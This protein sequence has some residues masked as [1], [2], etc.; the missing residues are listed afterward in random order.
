MSINSATSTIRSSVYQT[1]LDKPLS[2]EALYK[3]KLKYGIYQSP[4]RASIGVPS[5]SNASDTAALLAASTDL[6]VKPY[7]RTIAEDAQTAALFAK[8]KTINAYKR[9]VAED[10]TSASSKALSHSKRSPTITTETSSKI[11][12][13]SSAAASSVLTRTAAK[14]I[15]SLASGSLASLYEF[16]AVR[17][18]TIKQTASINLSKITDSS[19]LKAQKA[20]DERWNPGKDYRSGLQ[21]EPK[22]T[23]AQLADFAGSAAL[24]IKDYEI[25]EEE[26]LKARAIFKNS[27][28]DA[29]VLAQASLNADKTLKSI[30]Q[31]LSSRDLFLNPEFNKAALAI[32]QLHYEKRSVAYNGKV[33]LG[34]GLFMTQEELDNIARKFVDPVLESIDKTATLQREK[35]ARELA[36]KQERERIH[37][38]AKE[39][40]K[41]AKLEEKRAKEEAK[42]Q[43]RRELEEEKSRQQKAKQE[44]ENLKKDELKKH[45]SILSSK[46][47]EEVR[48][49]EELLAKQKAEE[50]RISKEAKE[51]QEQRDAELQKAQDERD[52]KLEPILDE[53]KKES[54]KLNVLNEE[55]NALEEIHTTHL[56]KLNNAK[57]LLQTSRDEL[58]HLSSVFDQL[59]IDIENSTSDQ[60]KLSK[61][62]ES[63]KVEAEISEKK[64]KEIE[65]DA[66]VKN[67]EIEQLKNETLARK[68]ELELKLQA[69]KIAVLNEEKQILE[70]L[71][72]SEAEEI[73]ESKKKA[74]GAV[75]S[76]QKYSSLFDD[77][78]EREI[79]KDSS[80]TNSK[81]KSTTVTAAAS[82]KSVVNASGTISPAK[83]DVKTESEIPEAKETHPAEEDGGEIKQ[84]F[85]GFTQGSTTE[86]KEGD[87]ESNDK[88][89]KEDEGKGYFKEEF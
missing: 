65:E 32:A 67:L 37:H 77:A 48:K 80:K 85:S 18:G 16:D 82:T 15:G 21:T 58:T 84:T 38:E 49:R 57:T 59:Q 43:R 33:N 41:K 6:T 13:S 71:P 70:T 10:A 27:L 86:D 56:A 79:N 68:Q 25:P 2:P 69:G 9:E 39:A 51:A 35:D 5:S 81:A 66:N 30:D 12:T 54:D 47:K 45:E 76:T 55:R 60:E 36:E 83:E 72:P 52:T 62:A 3:A 31:G 24:A 75:P 64:L 1:D 28:I 61:K 74:R 8:G 26:H 7:Q 34:G 22:L 23:D 78:L 19:K 88:P 11:S 46:Q 20:V 87:S 73:E 44:L 50:E 53:L 4:S 63:K 14:S 40:E 42:L 89:V 17:N 29:K